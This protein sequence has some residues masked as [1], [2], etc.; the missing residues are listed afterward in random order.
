M[1]LITHTIG[2]MAYFIGQNPR[3]AGDEKKGFSEKT[4]ATEKEDG[5]NCSHR[6]GE[7]VYR[8][9]MSSLLC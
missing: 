6:Q 4:A 5:R 1:F 7:I 8:N 2:S 3:K 9:S